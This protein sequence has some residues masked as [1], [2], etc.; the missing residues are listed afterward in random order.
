MIF[1]PVNRYLHVSVA[2]PP[3]AATLS[4]IVLPDDYKPEPERYVPATLIACADDV[5]FKDKLSEG[6]EVLID[7][8]MVEEIKLNNETITL[9]LDNYIVGIVT[10]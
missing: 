3:E 5:R 2:P 8:S 4:G 6:A 9:I 10:P 1:K 7:R